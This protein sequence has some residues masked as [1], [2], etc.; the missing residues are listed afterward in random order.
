MTE[1]KQRTLSRRAAT[2]GT[3]SSRAATPATERGE[4]QNI[5]RATLALNALAKS[6]ESG[7]RMTDVIAQ[8]GL[9]KGTVHRLLAG[10]VANGWVEYEASTGNYF[11]G[12]QLLSWAIDA[13][14]RFG[15]AQRFAPALSHLA[16]VTEDTVFLSLRS[17]TDSVCVARFEGA[18]PIKTLT[19]N[20]GDRRP[21]GIGAGS[22]ALLAYLPPDEIEH[23]LDVNRAARSRYPIDESLLHRMISTARQTGFAFNDERVIKGMSAVGV[24][25]YRFD[26][27]PIAAISIA[28][29]TERLQGKR[30]KTALAHLRKTVATVEKTLPA[31][32]HATVL[33]NAVP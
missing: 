20:V 27:L 14:N 7:L 3:S 30:L 18:F 28:A 13:S 12:M 26:K 24:P 29:V 9:S 22:L 1:S 4:H 21:M 23:I 11:L 10:L 15:L 8:T 5:R 25:V 17:G 33:S 19:L 2:S 31:V 16:E 32:L 6:S